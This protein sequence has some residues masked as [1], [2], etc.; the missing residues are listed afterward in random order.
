[1]VENRRYDIALSFAGEDRAYVEMVAEQLK[2]RDVSFFYDL[3]E[4]ADLWGKDLYVHL[5]EVYRDKSRYTLMFISAHYKEKVWCNHERR[6][7]QARA[8]EENSE[9]ILPTRF[10]DTEIPG[11]LSTTGFIDLRSKSPVEVALLVCEKLGHN[12]NTFKADQLPPPKNPAL[13]GEAAFNYS[14]HNGNFVIGEGH[15]EFRTHWS[16]ASNTSIHCYNDHVRGIALAPRGADI[17]AL[18]SVE[19]LDFTSRSRSPEIGRIVVLQ[20]RNGIYAALLISKIRDDTRGDPED[21]LSFQYWILQDGSS[22]F[23]A[24]EP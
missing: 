22:D 18:P 7:A 8:I 15:F 24:C 16:K 4:Q 21:L 19:E 20:N 14:N 5:T 23:G 12:L 1:M 13:T 3:Y 9:Y 11:I 2:V 10:D 17:R 6:A